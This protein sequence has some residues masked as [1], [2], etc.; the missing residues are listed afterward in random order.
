M[1]IIIRK[2]AADELEILLEWREKVLDEV[3][4][5][6]RWA[7]SEKIMK[8]NKEY[9][10]E[11]L[12][13]GSHTACFAVDNG[14]GRIVGCGGICYQHELPSPENISGKNGYLMNIYIDPEYRRHGT[15]RKMVEF[16]IA[17][18]KSR[19]VEKIYL[20]TS[21]AGEKLYYSLGFQTLDGYMKLIEEKDMV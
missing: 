21:T 5:M 2:A 8:S 13:D 11:H 12:E 3:F 15:G 4:W 18:A 19:G 16:L 1:D 10:K 7:D 17:D 6:S 20:E 9:Y 14:T